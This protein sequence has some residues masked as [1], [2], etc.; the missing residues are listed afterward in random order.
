VTEDVVWTSAYNISYDQP[1]LSTSASAT[2]PTTVIDTLA[3]TLPNGFFSQ[4]LAGT[5]PGTTSEY[6][7]YTSGSL[8]PAIADRTQFRR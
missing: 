1:D 3:W 8:N 5:D 6:P 4:L 2:D 7:L